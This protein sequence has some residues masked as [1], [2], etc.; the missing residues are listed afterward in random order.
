MSAVGAMR[1]WVLPLAFGRQC[2]TSQAV[3][4]SRRFN[5]YDLYDNC[6]YEQLRE[7]IVVK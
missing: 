2:A 3:N 7:N 1:C 5:L 4:R 6:S